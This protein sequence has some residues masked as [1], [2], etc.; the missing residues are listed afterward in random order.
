MFRN[1]LK[2]SCNEKFKLLFFL[3]VFF[4]FLVV[5]KILLMKTPFSHIVDRGRM[6]SQTFSTVRDCL[7]AGQEE[8]I[9]LQ[10]KVKTGK[11]SVDE[12]LEKF[13]HWQMGKT[14]LELIQ[15]VIQTPLYCG[16][17]PP[18]QSPSLF[19]NI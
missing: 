7:A 11:L 18:L 17:L 5:I 14:G 10:E 2:T 15:Q 1:C 13:K 16:M 9:L 3:S 6:E 8:L 4:F 12:A 19:V